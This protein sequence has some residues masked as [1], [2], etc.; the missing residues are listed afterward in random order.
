VKSRF[1]LLTLPGGTGVAADAAWDELIGLLSHGSH[2]CSAKRTVHFLRNRAQA[3]HV[4]VERSY[5]DRDHRSSASYFYSQQF[6]ATPRLCSRYHFFRG[7]TPPSLQPG[8]EFPA[9][10]YLGYVV[11]RPLAEAA[12]GRT[13]LRFDV[14]GVPNTYL[15]CE[16]V[17]RPHLNESEL[18]VAGVPYCQQDSA[19]M[20]CAETSIWAAARIMKKRYGHPLVLASQVAT[21][22]TVGFLSMGRILPSGG[23]TTDQM[24]HIV[25]S[26]GFGT[27]YYDRKA[28]KST[29][30]PWEWDPISIC[31]PYLASGIPVILVGQ[32][33]AVTACGAITYHDRGSAKATGSSELH[34]T[35]DWIRA[36]IVQDDAQGP[37]RLMPRSKP[38]YDALSAE[39]HG[40]LLIPEGSAWWR[41]AADIEAALIPLP[42]KVYFT[43]E[44]VHAIAAEYLGGHAFQKRIRPRLER[45]AENGLEGAKML[46]D[47]LAGKHGGVVY[48][49]R[50][51][52]SVE[53]RRDFGGQPHENPHLREFLRD[54]PLPRLVW[55]VE[56]TT[57]A[58]F[59][60]AEPLKRRVLGELHFDPTSQK[61]AGSSA[62]IF[63]HY[64]GM[65]LCRPE[66][67]APEGSLK[68]EARP[69]Q[70]DPPIERS[71]IPF[72]S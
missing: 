26:L 15:S 27:L 64:P 51:R 16:A 5:I 21:L 47:A 31:A 7:E 28:T 20:S 50:C 40:D 34:R 33:H 54:V 68:L 9:G 66:I 69:F 44:D 52:K 8:Q 67:S 22:D 39:G 59:D 43:A 17:F 11:Q 32:E 10:D 49:V 55:V 60:S 57:R 19:I 35:R 38:E 65:A 36:L 48:S 61:L 18:L 63:A 30:Q 6:R 46:L 1:S 14:A 71:G 12:I 42:Q 29:E 2:D 24:A 72:W 70:S 37:Y 25:T 45:L 13:V 41:T 62:L 58:I 56:F 4:I 53:V 23:L 3:R